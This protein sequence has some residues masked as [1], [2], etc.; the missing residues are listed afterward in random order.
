MIEVDDY[1]SWVW[2]SS[3][4]FPRVMIGCTEYPIENIVNNDYFESHEG[5]ENVKKRLL[6]NF[7]HSDL[8]ELEKELPWVTT[9]INHAAAGRT[10]S[11][12]GLTDQT[13]VNIINKMFVLGY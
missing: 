4:G 10:I 12:I 8:A 6:D 7:G 13:G 5:L 9:A 3:D 11:H 1:K 2:I